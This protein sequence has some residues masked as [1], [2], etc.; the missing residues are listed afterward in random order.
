MT[1]FECLFTFILL[2]SSPKSKSLITRT[3]VFPRRVIH[4]AGQLL[5]H[6]CCLITC[7]NIHRSAQFD[8][9]EWVCQLVIYTLGWPLLLLD[10]V[11]QLVSME[12]QLWSGWERLETSALIRDDICPCNFTMIQIY[13]QGLFT[14]IIHFSVLWVF[15][16]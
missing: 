6:K 8:M 15:S 7:V 13:T 12:T 3:R 14:N 16:F 9:L 5:I 11:G 4:S 2:H 1:L 10:V